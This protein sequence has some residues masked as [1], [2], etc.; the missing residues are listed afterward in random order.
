MF[1]P[2]VQALTGC[3]TVHTVAQLSC[4]ATA[5]AGKT[6]ATLLTCKVRANLVI[7]EKSKKCQ[8]KGLM[9]DSFPVDEK[10]TR[11]AVIRRA[12][13]DKIIHYLKEMPS[14]NKL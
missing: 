14:D 10:R 6:L 11:S 4:Y 9:V 8:F 2:D 13:A 3:L 5:P 1:C 12:F 7:A